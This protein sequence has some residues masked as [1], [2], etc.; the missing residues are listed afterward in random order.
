MA[1]DQEREALE[2]LNGRG[3]MPPAVRSEIATSCQRSVRSGL[4]P[5]R[6]RVPYD[7]EVNNDALLVQAA[8]PVLEGSLRT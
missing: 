2:Y 3:R 7:A 4:R 5:D 6:F 8:R 1:G